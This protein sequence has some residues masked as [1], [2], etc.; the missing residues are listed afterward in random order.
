LHSIASPWERRLKVTWSC[1][2]PEFLYAD[3]IKEDKPTPSLPNAFSKVAEEMCFTDTS[4]SNKNLAYLSVGL[5]SFIA[6]E[7]CLSESG[8]YW[9]IKCADILAAAVPNASNRPDPV[10]IY[11]FDGG[12]LSIHG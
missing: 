2:C 3:D 1:S 7:N 8:E 9:T 5:R 11:G 12:Q 10:E 6:V 4:R